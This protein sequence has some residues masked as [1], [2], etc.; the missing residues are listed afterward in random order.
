MMLVFTVIVDWVERTL[1]SRPRESSGDG[2]CRSDDE[3][4]M[5]AAR[6]L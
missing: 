5:R 3:S 1:F 2:Q 4:E 6:N